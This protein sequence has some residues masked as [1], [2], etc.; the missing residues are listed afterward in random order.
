MIYDTL[1]ALE[2]YKGI[3]AN[4]D[5]AIDYIM[6]NPLDSLEVGPHTID[7]ENVILHVQT[8]TT[9]DPATA[10]YEAHRKYIDI[11]FNI[12][13]EELCFYTPL[14]GLSEIDSFDE[15]KDIGFYD[16]EDVLGVPLSL[17]PGMFT[18]LF[19]HDAHKPSCTNQA[20]AQIRKV[21]V[22]VRV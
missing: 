12:E 2:T 21:V 5:T 15:T 19:P 4:L 22:K 17:F 20:A 16:S 14:A 11:Q 3:S 18:I 8:Y 6:Q 1:Q 9:R 13:G 7:G 10:L